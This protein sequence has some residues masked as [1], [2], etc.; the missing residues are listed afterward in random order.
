MFLTSAFENVALIA[1]IGL[2]DEAFEGVYV[3]KS[4]E[5]LG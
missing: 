4:G 5:P 1:W 2:S 3:W